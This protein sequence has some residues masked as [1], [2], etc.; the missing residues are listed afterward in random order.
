MTND[1]DYERRVLALIEAAVDV[2]CRSDLAAEFDD[3]LRRK[4][5]RWSA[6]LEA[7][8]DDP[9]WL[10]AIILARLLGEVEDP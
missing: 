1:A 2:S 4:D 7:V 3:M 8:K 9:R 6:E 10:E 5:V